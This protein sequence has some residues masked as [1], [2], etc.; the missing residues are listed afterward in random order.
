[1]HLVIVILSPCTSSVNTC[2][3]AWYVV[4]TA[5]P[6]GQQPVPDLPREDGRTL[7]LV[8]S[9]LIHHAIGGHA[10]LRASNGTRFDW[11]GFVIPATKAY[12]E[13]LCT[14]VTCKRAQVYA[15]K[16]HLSPLS[17]YMYIYICKYHCVNKHVSYT[18]NNYYF[19]INYDIRVWLVC[20]SSYSVR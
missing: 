18:R 20:A 14:T 13:A 10:R 12:D 2:T 3:Y 9:N 11:T 1:M 15:K 7:A 6:F 17:G 19:C 4:I 5:H 16:M 8:V